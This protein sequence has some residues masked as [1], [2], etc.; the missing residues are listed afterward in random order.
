MLQPLLLL[1]VLLL[2]P[3]LFVA[4]GA[5]VASVSMLFLD[6]VVVASIDAVDV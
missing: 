4:N 5:Y 6:V 3:L 2:M 1:I